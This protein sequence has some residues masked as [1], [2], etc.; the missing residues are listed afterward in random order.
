MVEEERTQ[1]GTLKAL[2]YKKREITAKYVW[3]ALLSTLLGSLLGVVLGESLLPSLILRTY[4]LVYV[5]LTQTVVRVQ[6]LN[7]VIAIVLA[8]CATVGGAFAACRRALSDN[9]AALMRP[10]APQAGRRTFVE[11][12]SYTHLTLPTK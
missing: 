9:P 6:V 3:Y 10:A 8:V 2:G 12:V 7:A 4:R 11:A 1:I 5:N